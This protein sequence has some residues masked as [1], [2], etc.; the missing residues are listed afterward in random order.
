MV[1]K[2]VAEGLSYRNEIP[3]GLTGPAQVTK[4]SGLRYADLDLTYVERCRS[5][6]SWA[7]LRYDLTILWRTLGVSARGEGLSY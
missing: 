3:A 6:G 7:L 1:A 5:L 4:G 2:Q